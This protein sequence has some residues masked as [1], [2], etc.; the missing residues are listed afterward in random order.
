MNNN[1]NFNSQFKNRWRINGQFNR[2]SENISTTLLRGGPSFITPGSQSFNLNL[3]SDRSKK[4]SF[5]LGNYHGS[6]DG[7][8]SRGHEYY[9]EIT[10]RPSNS[11]S[12]SL[13]PGYGIQSQE[14]QYVTAAGPT[15]ILFTCLGNSIRKR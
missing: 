9:G 3:S 8:S 2:Q 10:Y 4:F 15:I 6:G 14:L 12:L 1:I 5:F 13:N 7:N 11:V